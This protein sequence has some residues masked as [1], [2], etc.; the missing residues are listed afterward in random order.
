MLV[1]ALCRFARY[2]IHRIILTKTSIIEIAISVICSSTPV[3]AKF[4][5]IYIGN[6]SLYNSLCYLFT[7]KSSNAGSSPSFTLPSFIR[8]P[9]PARRRRDPYSQTMP[10]TNLSTTHLSQTQHILELG[11]VPDGYLRLEPIIYTANGHATAKAGE[12]RR[13]VSVERSSLISVVSESREQ[14]KR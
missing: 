9:E 7:T 8:R 5:R 14:I 12:I 4:T 1:R 2:F 3:A 11:E 6:S 13:T 10:S